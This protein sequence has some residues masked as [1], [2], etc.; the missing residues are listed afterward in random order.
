MMLSGA[1]R[2]FKWSLRRSAAGWLYRALKGSRGRTKAND[3]TRKY[4]ERGGTGCSRAAPLTGCRLLRAARI[5]ELM[6][7]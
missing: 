5:E 1:Y 7:P 3:L 4:R 6:D 2:L